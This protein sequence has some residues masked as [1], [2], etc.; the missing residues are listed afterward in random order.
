MDKRLPPKPNIEKIYG[1]L[2][3]IVNYEEKSLID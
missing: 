2:G 3:D 1:N